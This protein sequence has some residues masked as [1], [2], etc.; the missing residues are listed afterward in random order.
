VDGIE[1]NLF[2]IPRDMEKRQPGGERAAGY[3]KG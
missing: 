3:G 2:Y 1:L